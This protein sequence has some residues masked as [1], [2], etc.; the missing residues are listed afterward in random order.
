MDYEV[1]GGSMPIVEMNLDRGEAIKCEA[2]A[3]AWMS[4]NMRLETVGGGVGKMLGRAFSNESMFENIYTAEDGPGMISFATSYMGS[5]IP[6]EIGPG[7][8]IIIQKSA[9]LCSTLDV[10][11]KVEFQKKLAGALFGGEGFIMQRLSGTGMAFLEIDGTA[12]EYEL[13][14]G[15]SMI[16]S[17]GHLAM[18]DA[19]CKMDVETQKGG[20]KNMAFSG[21]GMFNTV[22]TGPGRIVL[23]TMP[24]S[25]LYGQISS[26]VNAR[27]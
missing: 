14:A 19:S 11:R 12:M 18:M 22:V 25:A 21:E 4:S 15:E 10:E 7:R 23:Q 26:Y 9:F 27:K 20:L 3:M 5:I 24:K 2:G 6:I 8:E 17:T 1:K 16:I 13:G